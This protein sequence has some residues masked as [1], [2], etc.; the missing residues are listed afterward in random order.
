[1]PD[2]VKDIQAFYDNYPEQ[3]RL[4]RH[5]I[6]RDVTWRYLD[7]YLPPKGNILEIGAATGAYTIPLAK[8]GYRV[9]AVDLS[10]KLIEICQKRVIEEGLE[11][12]VTCL[13]A[14]ARDLS[15]VGKKLFDAVLIMGPLYHLVEEEDRKT[16]LKEA[17]QRLKKGGIIFSAFASRYGIWGSVMMKL[18]DYI[19]YQND[20]KS[21]L[22]KGKDAELAYQ[23]G[24]FRAYFS[25][26]TEIIPLH[27]RMGFK[28]LALASVEPAAVAD[29][30]Y[31]KLQGEIR[32]LWLDLLFKV[33]SEK[34][35]IGASPHVLYVGVKEGD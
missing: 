34:T 14:D 33:S 15:E 27:E 19:K 22:E 4:E 1:M 31:N 23:P 18:P 24:N 6:E 29:P 25:N 7:K 10:T 12:K 8:R 32:K 5:Q 17:Y 26:V 2:D 30:V 20:V 21:V 35:V 3:D 13:V 28:T 11:K 16:A 9:T